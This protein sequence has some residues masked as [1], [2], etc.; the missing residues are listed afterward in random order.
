MKDL[1]DTFRG[2]MLQVRYDE[3]RYDRNFKKGPIGYF[4]VPAD[5]P[6]VKCMDCPVG[7]NNKRDRG[8]CNR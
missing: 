8:G 4:T 3:E 5:H 1:G 6:D 2:F 7:G